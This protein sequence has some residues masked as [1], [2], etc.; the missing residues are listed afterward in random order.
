MKLLSW[1]VPWCVQIGFSKSIFIFMTYLWTW[2]VVV[3]CVPVG[4]FIVEPTCLDCLTVTALTPAPHLLLCH[5]RFPE[6]QTHPRQCCLCGGWSS[7]REHLMKQ[8]KDGNQGDEIWTSRK[9]TTKIL[10]VYFR[11]RDG[12]THIKHGLMIWAVR[13]VMAV[14]LW[15]GK[16]CG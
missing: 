1:G 4:V 6:R 16:E 14:K 15:K 3:G 2:V 5:L 11:E 12:F 9:K 13:K 10:T 7:A 8:M